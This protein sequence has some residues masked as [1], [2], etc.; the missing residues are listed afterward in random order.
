MTFEQIFNIDVYLT[1]NGQKAKLNRILAEVCEALDGTCNTD[2]LCT[3]LKLQCA[4]AVYKQNIA[5]AGKDFI[6]GD[7]PYPRI[8][9]RG[10]FPVGEALSTNTVY[11]R[12]NPIRKIYKKLGS[13]Q[14]ICI[15]CKCRSQGNTCYPRAK[16]DFPAWPTKIYRFMQCAPHSRF[17][18]QSAHTT[19]TAHASYTATRCLP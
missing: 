6:S 15:A 3:Q 13:E 14:P 5:M 16:V 2:E 11:N 7:D 4:E 1:N 17:F 8:K 12:R 9:S 18:F 10:L 19:A